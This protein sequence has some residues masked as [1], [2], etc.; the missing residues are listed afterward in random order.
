[1]KAMIFAAGLGTRL[2]P[3]TDNAPKAL[4]PLAGKTLLYH[5]ITR[6]RAAGVDEFVVNVHHFPDMIVSYLENEFKDLNIKVSDERDKLLETGGGIRRAAPLLGDAEPFIVHNVDIISDL[7]LQ[8]FESRL[9]P[10]AMSALLVSE[11]KTKRYLLFNENMRLAG[12]T[13]ISTGAV[14]TPFRNLD[15]ESCRKMAFGGIHL[16]SPEI[17]GTF[18]RIDR[19]P[20]A[21]P[22]YDG[23]GRLIEGSDRPLGERFP[24]MD[25][26]LRAAAEYE[27]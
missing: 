5:V 1:M 4:A 2:K 11:R 17:F 14:K 10:G 23:D 16:M 12:W 21:F 22:L 20:S 7:D 9:R 6:L 15:V 27:F 3:F 19:E 25:Y 24:I 18:D 26:Y 8:W 13:D